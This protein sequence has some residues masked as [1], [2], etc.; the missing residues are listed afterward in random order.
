MLVPTLP[1]VILWPKLQ[2]R[3]Y[4]AL[5]KPEMVL[6]N[7]MLFPNQFPGVGLTLNGVN[8]TNNSI[9][10]RTDIGT[11][12]AALFCTTTYSPCCTS[13]NP[14]THWFFPD[15]SPVV[16]DAGLP[17]YRTRSRSNPRAV[18][19]HRNPEGTTTGIFRCDML[20]FI[21]DLQSLYVGIYDS[22]TGES[23]I[24]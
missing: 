12:S 4:H 13:L 20:D 9:V 23:C 17:Y 11:G 3:L 18:T 2:G 15:G 10:T 1:K 16:N 8:Y 6:S 22:G 14:D 24:Y 5:R 7:N 21:G 19:L